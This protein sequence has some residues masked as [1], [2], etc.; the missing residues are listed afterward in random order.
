MGAHGFFAAS[1][2]F[3]FR[4][5][6]LAVLAGIAWVF[7]FGVLHGWLFDEFYRWVTREVTVERTAFAWYAALTLLFVLVVAAVMMVFDY[8][9]VRAV[10]EDRRSMI[11]ALLAGAR[12]VRRHPAVAGGVFLLNALL[13]AA[14]VGAYALL[15]RGAR[16]GSG[17]TCTIGLIVA[18]AYIA[19]ASVREAVLLR[20]SRRALPGPPRTRRVHRDAP[21]GVAGLARHRDDHGRAGGGTLLV[22]SHD[23]E[24]SAHAHA[25]PVWHR[26]KCTPWKDSGSA[27]APTGDAR[28]PELKFRRHKFRL[29][30]HVHGSL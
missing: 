17:F 7:V 11:G 12:F 10:V 25:T 2:V 20:V 4:F 8:A 21:R 24:C 9:K 13:F 22:A 23:A 26:P 16:G 27:C 30:T 3:F 5:L 14:A 18:Q 15:A 29:Y 6:R 19:R 28:P 1:G